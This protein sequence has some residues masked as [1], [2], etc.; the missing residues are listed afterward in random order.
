M[1]N[2]SKVLGGEGAAVL[3]GLRHPKMTALVQPRKKGPMP[4]PL[5]SG[6]EDPTPKLWDLFWWGLMT[7]S[8]ALW[9]QSHVGKEDVELAQQGHGAELS[10]SPFECLPGPILL[11]RE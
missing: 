6:I 9:G 7:F 10:I 8:W 3:T 5:G 2:V 1:G 4:P 11:S